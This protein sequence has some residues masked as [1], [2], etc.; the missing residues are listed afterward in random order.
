M[1]NLKTWLTAIAF[2]L[3]GA[4]VHVN[5]DEVRCPDGGI[6]FQLAPLSGKNESPQLAEDG[7][8]R[9]PQGMQLNESSPM[10]A[11]DGFGRTPLG[12]RLVGHHQT[13]HA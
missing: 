2:S 10:L 5:A 12:K 7:Y 9:T 6:C 8:S 4:A 13:G 1:N 3:A 11:A